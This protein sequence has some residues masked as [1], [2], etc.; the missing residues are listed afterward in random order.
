MIQREQVDRHHIKMVEPSLSS[1][2]ME[3][4]TAVEITL[5][6]QASQQARMEAYVACE[7]YVISVTGNNVYQHYL[8]VCSILGSKRCLRCVLRL[9]CI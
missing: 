8:Y 3:L 6:P 5:N 9:A 1:L 4:A 7:K 2:A